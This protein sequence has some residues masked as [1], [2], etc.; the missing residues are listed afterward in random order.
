MNGI[1]LDFIESLRTTVLGM[2]I[3]LITLY[4]LSLI[5]DFMKLI[6][7]PQA[8]QIK[9]NELQEKLVEDTIA[10][11]TL[12]G[13]TIDTDNNELIAVITAALSCYLDKP[14]SQIKI[15]TIRQLHKK[16][17]AWG[18]AARLEKTRLSS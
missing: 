10:E 3:V 15:G 6:F 14:F 17:P 11:Q 8:K 13:G 12:I 1:G 9:K 2:G 4:L 5:L 7:Y 18:M 16:T